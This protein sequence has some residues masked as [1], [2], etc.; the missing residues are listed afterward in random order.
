MGR[1]SVWMASDSKPPQ[2]HRSE[3]LIPG[4]LVYRARSTHA[5]TGSL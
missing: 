1:D 3:T 5:N 4:I 2:K